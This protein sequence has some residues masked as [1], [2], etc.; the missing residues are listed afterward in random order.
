MHVQQAPRRCSTSTSSGA[1]G[2][3]A[4]AASAGIDR[5][6]RREQEQELARARGNDDLLHQQLDPVGDRLQQAP[7]ADAVGADAHLDP[8]DHL[9]LDSVR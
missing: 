4:H 2:I 9:A 3:T 1:N 5:H 7:R 6:D 8:A